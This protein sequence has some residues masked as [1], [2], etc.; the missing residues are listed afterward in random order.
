[1]KKSIFKTAIIIT[2]SLFISL[3]ISAQSNSTKEIEVV[4]KMFNA[5]GTGDMNALTSTVS[6]S[7]IWTYHGS[8]SIPYSGIFKGKKEVTRF[9][10]SIHSNVEILDF[11]IDQIISERQ[12]VIVLGSEKQKIK[13]NGEI[14]KQNWVQIYQVENGLITKMDEYANT[15]YSEK[16]F[17]K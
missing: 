1:M 2:I 3:N 8:N 7:T 16:L 10:K 17:N 6:D 15:A 14:L 9:I 5:F 12:T 13:N 4:N 11:K